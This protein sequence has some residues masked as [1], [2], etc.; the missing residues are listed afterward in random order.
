MGCLVRR[1]KAAI[2]IRLR[3]LDSA[4]WLAKTDRENKAKGRSDVKCKGAPSL[5]GALQDYNA[6]VCRIRTEK[7]GSG[8]DKARR[9]RRYSL[10]SGEIGWQ[11]TSAKTPVAVVE[12]SCAQS[13]DSVLE[14]RCATKESLIVDA[15]TLGI[16]GY[17][18][19]EYPTQGKMHKISF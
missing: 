17:A 1:G 9:E 13:S 8:R 7:R 19:L 16:D 3:C 15:R 10:K 4:E 11:N 18:L 14:V 5:S 2:E 12:I 6:C